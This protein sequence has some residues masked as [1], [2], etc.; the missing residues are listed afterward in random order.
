MTKDIVVRMNKLNRNVCAGGVVFSF[1]LM[2][3][4]FAILNPF[5]PIVFLGAPGFFVYMLISTIKGFNEYIT[6]SEDKIIVKK[7]LKS[8]KEY[9]VMDINT[10]TRIDYDNSHNSISLNFVN[11]ESI[12]VSYHSE[13]FKLFL[14]KITEQLE[15]ENQ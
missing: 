4:A 12:K 13:N 1:F 15:G 3:A 5:S 2:I 9:N 10:V 6:L 11:G 7:I 14:S 8:E